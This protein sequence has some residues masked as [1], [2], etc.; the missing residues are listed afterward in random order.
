MGQHH[1]QYC[2]N[3]FYIEKGEYVEV[4][5]DSRIMVDVAYFRKINPNYTRPHINELARPSSSNS[6]FNH[7]FATD[8]EE[9]KA[10]CLDKTAMSEDDLMICS[11]TVYGWSFGNKRWQFVVDGITE[12]VWNPTSFDNLAIPATKKKI[13]TAL[14]KAYISRFSDVMIDDFV[15]GKGQGLITLLHGP[16]GVGKIL[17]VEGLSEHLERPLYVIS[18][19]ELGQDAKVLEEQLSTIF[20]LAH[21]WKAILLLDEADVFVQSRSFVNPHNTLVSVF[22][23]T[24]EY[25]R[26]IMILTTNRVKDIDNAIQS[27]ISVALHYELLG[28]DTRKTIWES[29]L[30]EAATAKGRAKYTSADLDWLSRKEV[31]LIINV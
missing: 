22:L 12:I 6:I 8:A 10:N 16:P 15:E 7:F 20:R 30:K 4:P 23:R 11:Q 13:I 17:T 9:A 25:Y 1:V 14:A 27:R 21:H 5:V 29:F 28:L 3:A 19:G 18:A 31:K 26:G 24:L 2:G